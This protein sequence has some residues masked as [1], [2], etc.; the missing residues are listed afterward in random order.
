MLDMSS[1]AVRRSVQGHRSDAEMKGGERMDDNFCSIC[2]NRGTVIC[3]KCHYI[4]RPDGTISFPSYYCRMRGAMRS[5]TDVTVNLAIALRD[6]IDRGVP[7]P[8]STV[9]QYNDALT[10]EE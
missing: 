7:L 9:M 5:T 8:I 3:E 6:Y 2:A 10:K 4:Q 1:Q